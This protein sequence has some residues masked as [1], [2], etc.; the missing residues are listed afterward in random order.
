MPK[1]HCKGAM[2]ALDVEL[3]IEAE[4]AEAAAREYVDWVNPQEI[5]ETEW[6]DVK[7]WPDGED[8]DVADLFTVTVHPERPCVEGHD[9]HEWDYI[10]T[11]G[12]GGGV[13]ITEKCRH[14]GRILEIDTWA[15]RPDTGEQGLTLYRYIEDE[16]EE[17]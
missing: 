9:D 1:Y 14:C 11:Y 5:P 16:C 2:D 13:I 7:V 3:I 4:S 6:W 12:H 10:S 17:A 15:Q 8:C